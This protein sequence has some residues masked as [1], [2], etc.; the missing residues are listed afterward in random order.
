MPEKYNIVGYGSLISHNSLK[1]DCPNKHF[2]PVIVKGYKRI[3]NILEGKSDILNIKKSRKSKFNGVLFKVNNPEF[4]KLK[5]REDIY[6]PDKTTCYDFKTKK[7]SYEC[8]VYLDHN[9]LIDRY[10]NKPNKN[11]FLLCRQAAYHIS[12]EFGKFWDNTT[13]T[14]DGKKISNWL[15]QNPSYATL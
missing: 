11:Y 8:F 13:F 7:I 14:S 9:L 15:K 4:T 12:K 1:E 3:F 5:K 2:I 6:T 10:H